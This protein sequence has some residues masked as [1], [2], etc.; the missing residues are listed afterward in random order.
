MLG[1]LSFGVR[2]LA[3]ASAFYDAVL[4]SLG[5]VRLWDGGDRGV[6]YGPPDGGEKLN[7]FSHADAVPPGPG[8]H[9]AFDAPSRARVDAFH[10]AALE[11]GGLDRGPPG[12]R[13][14]YGPSYYACF[15]SDLDGHRLEAVHQ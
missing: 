12:I 4:L 15:V 6:G 14:S 2:D 8:F 5:W 11:N 1:H 3:R 9:L 13:S 7:L 10:A